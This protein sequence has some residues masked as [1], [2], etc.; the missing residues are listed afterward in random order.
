M[1]RG[2]RERSWIPQLVL[3]AVGPTLIMLG[4]YLPRLWLELWFYLFA[5]LV[6]DV[7]HHSKEWEAGLVTNGTNRIW[8]IVGE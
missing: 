3:S 7:R 1:E 4:W 6:Q 8:M 5:L 2:G